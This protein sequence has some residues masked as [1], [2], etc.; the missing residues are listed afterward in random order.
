MVFL[1]VAL[2]LSLSFSLS[3]VPP[4]SVTCFLVSC[5]GVVEAVAA[6]VVGSRGSIRKGCVRCSKA[7]EDS[8]VVMEPVVVVVLVVAIAII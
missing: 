1:F 5:V 3:V 7:C 6:V 8:V 4:P 2:S